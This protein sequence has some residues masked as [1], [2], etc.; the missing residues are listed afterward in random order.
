MRRIR[1]RISKLRPRLLALTALLG[2]IHPLLLDIR[3]DIL[4]I[5]KTGRGKRRRRGSSFWRRR[6]RT[7]YTEIARCR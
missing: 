6:S 2:G 5:F 4:A 1:L 7:V 3:L